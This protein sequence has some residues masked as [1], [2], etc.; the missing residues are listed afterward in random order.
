MRNTNRSKSDFSSWVADDIEWVCETSTKENAALGVNTGYKY[1]QGKA[2]YLP[3][4]FDFFNKHQYLSHNFWDPHE[5]RKA[6]NTTATLN[7]AKLFLSNYAQK[8]CTVFSGLSTET[9]GDK[10]YYFFVCDLKEN[11]SI[12]NKSF[13][14]NEEIILLIYILV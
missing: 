10:D 11:P 9:V 14:I 4:S 5:N 3:I 6:L 1:I 7:I 13:P 2:K 12:P 8:N